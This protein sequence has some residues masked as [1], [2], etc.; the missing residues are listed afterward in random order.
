MT[1]N[2]NEYRVRDYLTADLI[3]IEPTDSIG[4]AR[5][6]MLGLGFHGLPV[7]ED[8]SVVGIV[9]SADLVEEWPA[10]EPVATIMSRAV[11]SVDANATVSVAAE[12]MRSE[13]IHHLVV[14]DQ[15]GLAGILS[16]FDLLAVLVSG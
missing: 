10:G 11:R 7:V 14:M 15:D 3:T 5:D 13:S 4:R 9:T 2:E 16:S 1:S 8:D 12:L 6:L